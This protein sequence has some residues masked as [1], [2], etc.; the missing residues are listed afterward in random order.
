MYDNY[1]CCVVALENVLRSFNIF[2]SW[3]FCVCMFAVWM[4]AY[5][6]CMQVPLDLHTLVCSHCIFQHII[7]WQLLA[8]GCNS[9][10]QNYTWMCAVWPSCGIPY[11]CT[12]ME[13]HPILRQQVMGN[14]SNKNRQKHILNKMER[15]YHFW[16]LLYYCPFL[17]FQVTIAPPFLVQVSKL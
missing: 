17:S 13:N 10:A 7:D 15:G 11:A 1:L 5:G 12:F 6:Q 2:G 9:L 8:S 16:W 14:L 3:K 4:S